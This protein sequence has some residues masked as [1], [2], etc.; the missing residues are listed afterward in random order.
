MRLCA[1][2]LLKNN[3]NQIRVRVGESAYGRLSHQQRL[4]L[5]I[6]CGLA[7][8]GTAIDN[9]DSGAITVTQER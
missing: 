6:N 9:S 4:S 1:E 2:I 8:R 3:D 7:R 5:L